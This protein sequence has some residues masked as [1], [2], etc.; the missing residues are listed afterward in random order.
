MLI[1]RIII[2]YQPLHEAI[3]IAT[4]GRIGVFR[5]HQR[6]TGM[7]YMHMTK[8]G[9]NARLADDMLH[10]PG[11]FVGAAALAR[12]FEVFLDDHGKPNL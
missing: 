10:V 1:G 8:A 7:V 6:S 5:K 4:N 2:R 11:H 3:Q 9:R 12:K